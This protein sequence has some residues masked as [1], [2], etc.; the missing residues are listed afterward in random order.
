MKVYRCI[1]AKKVG[2]NLYYC[3]KVYCPYEICD[4]TELFKTLVEQPALKKEKL[5]MPKPPYTYKQISSKGKEIEK[6]MWHK[7]GDK[8]IELAKEGVSNTEISNI[9]GIKRSNIYSFLSNK[10]WA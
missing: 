6:I 8:I 3:S 5:A 7:I 9:F 2:D 1:Y 10:G 4:R